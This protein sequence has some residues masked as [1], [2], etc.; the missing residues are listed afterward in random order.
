MTQK[1]NHSWPSA[2]T[3]NFE[4][5]SSSG[6]VNEMDRVSWKTLLPQVGEQLPLKFPMKQPRGWC[7]SAKAEAEYE[8]A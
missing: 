6:N 2:V 8:Q 3:E 5:E 1:S 4:L 7:E